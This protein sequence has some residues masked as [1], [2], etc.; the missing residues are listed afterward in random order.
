MDNNIER[1]LGEQP[2]AKLIREHKLKTHD[3][4]A[5]ST[6]Q[7][8]HKMIARAVKGRR[9]TV[10]VQTKILRALNKVTN[11]NYSLSDLFNY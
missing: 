9:L 1:N 8:S 6:E 4:V 7:L 3:V 5:N 10:N 11:K 2:I